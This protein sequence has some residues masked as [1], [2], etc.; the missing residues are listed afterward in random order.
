MKLHHW[1]TYART[2]SG[3]SNARIPDIF[4]SETSGDWEDDIEASE[5]WLKNNDNIY[6]TSGGRY[7]NDES[8]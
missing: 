4:V 8:S 1:K 7:R 5:T 3:L 2:L 6:Y